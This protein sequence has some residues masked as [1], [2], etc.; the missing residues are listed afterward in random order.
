[1]TRN[2]VNQGAA[3]ELDANRA[4]QRAN[5]LLQ[6]RQEAEHSYVEAKLNLA[7]IL[8]ARITSDFD[9]ADEAAYGSGTPPERDSSIQTALASRR[10]SFRASQ[11][12]SGRVTSPISQGD[13]AANDS[14]ERE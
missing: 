12:E 6:Q 3:A 4:M 14:A 5:S 7:N 13:Q 11:L 9:V 10:L 1:L 2:R 8:Q